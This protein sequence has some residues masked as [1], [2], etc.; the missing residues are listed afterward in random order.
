[1]AKAV[2]GDPEI[3]RS[4]DPEIDKEARTLVRLMSV[5]SSYKML[6]N[7]DEETLVLVRRDSAQLA[8][9]SEAYVHHR[10]KQSSVER[11]LLSRL[12][13]RV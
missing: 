6:N 3:Q 4:G 12:N 2:H 13:T 9:S 10:E 11:D 1:M 8:T 7:L 5:Y